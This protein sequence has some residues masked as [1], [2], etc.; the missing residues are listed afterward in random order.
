MNDF[1]KIIDYLYLFVGA[2]NNSETLENYS[3]DEQVVGTWIDGKTIYRKVVNF[4]MADSLNHWNNAVYM[5]CDTMI[6]IKGYTIV[7]N[8]EWYPLPNAGGN[9]DIWFYFS[10]IDGWIREKHNYEYVSNQ[11]CC[12]IIEYTK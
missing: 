2:T 5:P 1:L 8:G 9:E 3:T 11:S 12:L 4:T 7:N 6:S 10:R